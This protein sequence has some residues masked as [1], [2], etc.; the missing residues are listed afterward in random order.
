MPIQFKHKFKKISTVIRIKG[1]LDFGNDAMVAWWYSGFYKNPKDN[2][3]PHVLVHFREY[4]SPGVI[5]DKIAHRR[6]P[7]TSLGQVRVGTVWKNDRCKGEL[8]LEPTKFSLN[9]NEDGWRFT[10]LS[11]ARRKHLAPPFQ[12]SLYKLERENDANWLIEFDL[13]NGGK[14]FVPCLEFFTR[15]YGR[16]GELKRIVATYPWEDVPDSAKSRLYATLDEPEEAGKWKVRLRRRMFNGDVVFL[17]HAKYDNYT[18]RLTKRINADLQTMIDPKLTKPAFIQIAPWFRGPAELSVKGFSFD[19]GKSFLA[20]NIVGMS[21]PIGEQIHRGRENSNNAETAAPDGSPE[22]W[23]GR[24]ERILNINEIIDLTGD[25]EPDGDSPAVEIQDP[26][27][28]TLGIERAVIDMRADQA[29][30][31]S[32]K[33][34]KGSDASMFSAGEAHGSDKGIG[35]ASIH[36]PQTYESHGILRDM[37]DAMGSLHRKRPDLIRSLSWFTFEDGFISTSEYKLIPLTPFDIDEDVTTKV[38]RFPYLE[39]PKPG[40]RGFLVARLILADGPAYI[41][42][43]QRRPKLVKDKDGETKAGEDQFQGMVFRLK[44]ENQLVPWLRYFREQIRHA[45]GVVRRLTGSCSGEAESFSH[46]NPTELV[47]G[48]L[49]RESIVLHALSKVTEKTI[50]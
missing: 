17:A 33:H 32:G 50:R 38:K 27:F 21:D 35:H 23:A 37:W 41:I 47:D 48:C 28:V 5:G 30:T 29:K 36:A 14:L 3:Q 20:F 16:S 1:T 31:V 22:A 12:Q 2:S 4:I 15:C 25:G 10:S 6:I 7:L 39:P 8:D 18:T 46:R 19:D 13:P 34:G 9:F 26:V 44:H 24:P 43:L 42:E 40:L 45:K 11:E 49:P